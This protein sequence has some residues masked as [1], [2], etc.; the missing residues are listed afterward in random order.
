MTRQTTSAETAA[1]LSGEA[2]GGTEW[3]SNS[4][5]GYASD[6]GSIPPD[7]E[8]I[9]RILRNAARSLPPSTPPASERIA[10]PTDMDGESAIDTDAGEK[11]PAGAS[12]A[13]VQTPEGAG[14][15]TD[16]STSYENRGRQIIAGATERAKTGSGRLFGRAKAGI[17]GLV[18]LARGGAKTVGEA[19]GKGA[20][21]AVGFAAIEGPKA[22]KAT[23]EKVSE[24]REKSAT[25]IHK[26]AEDA[27][28]RRKLR[29]DNRE[30]AK[31]W[32]EQ[33]YGARQ[34]ARKRTL[35]E[36]ATRNQK[37]KDDSEK[38][39]TDIET[40]KANI[41][42]KKG[43]LKRREVAARAAKSEARKAERR[44]K[45]LEAK[46]EKAQD[47][48]DRAKE[49]SENNPDDIRAQAAFKRAEGNLEAA[50]LLYDAELN[51]KTE[52]DSKREDRF[53]EA[54]R[55]RQALGELQNK[56]ADAK[57]DNNGGRVKRLENAGASAFLRVAEFVDGS[58][59]A[60]DLL[61]RAGRA[62]K[63][64]FQ[65]GNRQEA[66]TTA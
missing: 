55:S 66:K 11:T 32:R 64:K 33:E 51:H 26:L 35:G 46:K 37:I 40:D 53:S 44:L 14:E 60:H 12:G 21:V 29:K 1:V 50:K 27:R 39:S 52:L 24:A 8:Q 9:W 42:G 63:R 45:R 19:A 30:A 7:S 10:S 3:D 25:K 18:R 36:I 20:S 28:Q 17:K 34:E 22:A 16:E 15:K 57:R 59:A 23:V 48:Y 61:M 5:R 65:G 49:A 13:V 47:R 41:P 56:V 31:T 43:E 38:R 6:G 2:S 58:T 4:I 62:I 54:G